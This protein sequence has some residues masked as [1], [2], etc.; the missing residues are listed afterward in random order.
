MS[1]FEKDDSVEKITN[2]R[3]ISILSSASIFTI[4][5]NGYGLNVII[6][7]E[8]KT[9]IVNPNDIDQYGFIGGTHE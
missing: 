6:N 7:G 1:K 9:V 5:N 8:N 2:T 3:P 4:I